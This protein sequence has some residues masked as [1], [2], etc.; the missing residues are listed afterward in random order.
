MYLPTMITQSHLSIA[1]LLGIEAF[2]S[3]PSL[4]YVLKKNPDMSFMDSYIL[5]QML[6]ASL[7]Q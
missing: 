3:L 4:F 5:E 1:V 2:L 7:I 6:T